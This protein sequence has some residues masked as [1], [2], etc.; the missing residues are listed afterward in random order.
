M[1]PTPELREQL[2]RLIDEVIP[3]G[4]ADTDTRFTDDEL[5]EILTA[6]SVIEEAAAEAW[7][8]KAARAMSERG[9]LEASEVG[10]ERL[11]FV[12]IKDYRDHCLAMA[13]YYR[14]KVPGRGSLIFGFEP[15]DILG[16]G[17]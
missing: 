1:T 15:P 6:A 14:S 11:R 5:D 8:R 12:S 4:G 10:D 17:V 9:G 16:T 2:R 3:Q 7:M 13:E